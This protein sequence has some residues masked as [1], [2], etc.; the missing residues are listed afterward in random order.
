M[1]KILFGLFLTVVTLSLASTTW[2]GVIMGTLEKID[3]KG[4]F[5]F[6]KDDKGK[7]HKVHFDNSTQKTGDI[8]AGAHVEVDEANGHAKSIKVME[9]KK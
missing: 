2:A 8:K 9:M 7:E 5:Y 1:S 4:S 3:D 6:V